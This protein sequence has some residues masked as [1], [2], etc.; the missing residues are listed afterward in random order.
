MNVR[1][2]CLRLGRVVVLLFVAAA[3]ATTAVSLEGLA[4]KERSTYC[5]K[6][7]PSASGVAGDP[8]SATG[9]ERAI[10]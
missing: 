4:T 7:S 5:R 6:Y 2:F 9:L 8:R 3:K 1:L 10:Q